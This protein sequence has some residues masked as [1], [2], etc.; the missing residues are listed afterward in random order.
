MRRYLGPHQQSPQCVGRNMLPS[1][2]KE[3]WGGI[4]KSIKIPAL[5]L[6]EKREVDKEFHPH[7]LKKDCV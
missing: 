3:G 7:Q 5:L 2:L 6:L 1:F 4:Y